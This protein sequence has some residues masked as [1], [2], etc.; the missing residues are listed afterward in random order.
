MKLANEE[1]CAYCLGILAFLCLVVMAFILY[2][3]IVTEYSEQKTLFYIIFVIGFLVIVLFAGLAWHI[4]S[5]T[6]EKRECFW[7]V[8]MNT[9]VSQLKKLLNSLKIDF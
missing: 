2:F 7:H 5:R 8:Q 9:E 4:I 6:R 1:R 3:A